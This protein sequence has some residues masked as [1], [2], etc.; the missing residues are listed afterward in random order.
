MCALTIGLLLLLLFYATT[1]TPTITMHIG[2][3]IPICCRQAH[4]QSSNCCCTEVVSP[5]HQILIPYERVYQTPQVNT[6]ACKY[7]CMCWCILPHAWFATERQLV[8]HQQNS[9]KMNRENSITLGT[10][11]PL[12]SVSKSSRFKNSDYYA[13]SIIILVIHDCCRNPRIK[14]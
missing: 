11:I 7:A 6:K 5:V 9:T 1:Q 8:P 4:S 14:V 3:L 10:T 13:F 12:S 2:T